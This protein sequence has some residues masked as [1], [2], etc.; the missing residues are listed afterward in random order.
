[1]YAVNGFPLILEIQ[2]ALLRALRRGVRVRTLF[3]NLTPTHHGK[4]FKGAWAAARTEATQLVHSRMDRLVAAG[5]EAYELVVPEHPLWER[6]LGPIHPHVHGKVMSVDG[7]VC[8]VGSAN[9]DITA[10][11]WETELLLIVEDRATAAALESR[12]DGL[13]SQSRRVDRD[14]PAWQRLARR[15]LWMRRLPGVMSV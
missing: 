6:G 1:V 2:H 7:R 8:S 12:V 5:A 11:Y 13:L 9:L 14:D 15:R 4:P 3:G 10:G